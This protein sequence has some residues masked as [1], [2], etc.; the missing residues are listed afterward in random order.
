MIPGLSINESSQIIQLISN[1]NEVEEI[2]LFGS[3]AKGNFKKGSD[4]DLTLKGDKLNLY[5]LNDI[6]REI[7]DLNM[8]YTID[9][10]IYHQ[11]KN[12]ELI[13]HIERIGQVVFR[14]KL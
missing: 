1:H 7:S 9:L 13:N 2:V 8:P 12:D 14:S 6:S 4:V 5:L 11:I 10:S 3:R